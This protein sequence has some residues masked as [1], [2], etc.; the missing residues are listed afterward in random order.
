MKN[1]ELLSQISL[2]SV[3]LDTFDKKMNNILS[4]IGEYSNVSRTYIFINNKDNTRT[5]NEYE[6]CN[7]G[8]IP[9]IRLYQNR[10]LSEVPSLLKLLTTEGKIFSTNI[11]ELPNDLSQIFIAENIKSLLIYPLYIDNKL[12]GLI[13]Y[14]E[15]TINRKWT[16]DE[17]NILKTI[18]GIISNLYK[19]YY[20][21]NK[22]EDD[23][24]YFENFFNTITDYI[25]IEDMQGKILHA[26]KAAIYNL[27]YSINELYNMNIMKLHPQDTDTF[28]TIFNQIYSNNLKSY[29]MNLIGKNNITI[30]VE[31]R[32]WKG[33][34]NSKDCIFQISKDLTKEQEALQKFTKIFKNNP[35]LM[36]LCNSDDHKFVDVNTSFVEKL[37]YSY[38]EI[39]GKN[40]KELNLFPNQNKHTK[41]TNKLYNSGNINKI[42]Q[43]VRCKNGDILHGLFSGEVI[44]SEG[45]QYS[46]TVMIDITEQKKMEK[47]LKE[48]SI[49]DSLTNIYNR[50]YIFELLESYIEKYKNESFNFSI[51]ILDIDFFKDIND[52]YG[53]VIGDYVLIEFTKTVNQ[54]LSNNQTLGRYGGEEF[55]ILSSNENKETTAIR[56]NQILQKM[57]KTS[58]NIKNN[59]IKF[60]FS[61]GIS[62]SIHLEKNDIS[63]DKIINI[64]D[65]R[66]YIAK[67]TGRNKVVYFDN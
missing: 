15:C 67:R 31:T 29:Q 10:E 33:K 9:V 26:N 61:A 40:A 7:K 58:F 25:F 42:E 56:I 19:N 63:I 17:I 35:A 53:H 46:L 30:P 51:A 8:I 11:E 16:K 64:S 37:G 23:R 34:W 65:E 36:A 50:R 60:T 1:I 49:R 22:I 20:A 24:Q 47:Q 57:N 48:I 62:D 3:N 12:V 2:I 18:S 45:K 59:N 39:I 44:E 66:L 41:T 13:G 27:G 38:E 54:K 5:T 28:Y 43:E 14:D 32:V 4:L 21:L 55:I 52:K 6:W